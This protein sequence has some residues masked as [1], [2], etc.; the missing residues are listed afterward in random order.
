MGH[1]S[2]GE[3]PGTQL[4][5]SHTSPGPQVT[6]AQGSVMPAPLP[7]LPEPPTELPP[8]AW[9]ALLVVLSPLETASLLELH[10]EPS[11]SAATASESASAAPRACL[12]PSGDMDQ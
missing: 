7:T 1:G 6:S 12:E 4:P 8:P 11:V 5:L 9:V 10:D 2:V 3:Q